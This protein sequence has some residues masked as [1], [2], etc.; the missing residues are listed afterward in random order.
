MGEY[1]RQIK[2]LPFVDNDNRA[3]WWQ[4]QSE[5][6]TPLC[7]WRMGLAAFAALRALG[8]TLPHDAIESNIRTHDAKSNGR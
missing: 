6:G 4:F 2:K 1:L 8:G 7:A 3:S 5:T